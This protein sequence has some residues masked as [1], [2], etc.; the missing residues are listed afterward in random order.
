MSLDRY[1]AEGLLFNQNFFEDTSEAGLKGYRGELVLVEGGIA[2]EKGHA[3]PPVDVMRGVAILGGEKMQLV[4]GA[5]DD[6]KSLQTFVE[7]FGADFAADMIAVIYVVN[8][9]N[10]AQVSI[11]DQNFVLIPMQQGV[12]WNEIIDELAL[13]KS[14]FKGMSAADKIVKLRDEL[15]DYEPNYPSLPFEEVA[16]AATDATR[17]GWGAV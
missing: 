17:E 14:D 15:K 13:E 5:I 12:P 3:K 7:K 1:K 4:I 11:G 6:I 9:E 16:A 10:P 8:I 2:D